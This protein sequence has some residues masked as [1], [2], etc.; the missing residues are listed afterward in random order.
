MLLKAITNSL[1]V[2][3]KQATGIDSV[4]VFKE[5]NIVSLLCSSADGFILVCGG[6]PGTQITSLPTLNPTEFA[7]FWCFITHAAGREKTKKC[8]SAILACCGAPIPHVEF[9]I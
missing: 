9:V 1:D 8:L 7:D 3:P 5:S 6:R 2:V 4:A